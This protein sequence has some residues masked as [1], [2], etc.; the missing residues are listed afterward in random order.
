MCNKVAVL[1]GPQDSLD[2]FGNSRSAD[3]LAKA[4]GTD[5]FLL[6]DDVSL[7]RG[8]TAHRMLVAIKHHLAHQETVIITRLE[9]RGKGVEGDPVRRITQ[10]WSLQGDLMAEIDPFKGEIDALV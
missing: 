7:I 1:F 5:I 10:I 3:D 4:L 6:P 2:R 8:E 9:C